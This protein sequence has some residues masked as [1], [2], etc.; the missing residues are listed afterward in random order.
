MSGKKTSTSINNVRVLGIEFSR[1]YVFTLP[2][3]IFFAVMAYP[4]LRV[5][6]LS[7]FSTTFLNPA[8]KEFVGIGNYLQILKGT[9]PF[10][11]AL[12]RSVLWVFGSVAL[13]TVLGTAIAILLDQGLRGRNVYRGLSIIPW[14]IPWTIAAMMWGWTFHTQ[15]GFINAILSRLGFISDPIAF[16]ST[17]AFAFPSLIVVDAWIGLPFMVVMLEAGL[18]AVPNQLYESARVD[19]ANGFQR[20]FYVTLPQLKRVLIT[21]TLLSTVWTFNSFDPIWVLTQGGPLHATETL[22]IA[23]YNA[24]FRMIGGGDLGQA[25]AMTIGQVILVS[26]IAFFYMRLFK[27]EGGFVS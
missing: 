19:G 18:K 7:F 26:I 14:G 8:M 2:L 12:G 17:P 6:Y 24:G 21:A 10:P 15:Y 27:R 11:P 23:I 20:L 16:L 4:L 25:A 5:V 1:G 13:K 9:N 3:L 22:P